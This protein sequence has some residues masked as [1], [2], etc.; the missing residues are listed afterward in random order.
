MYPPPPTRSRGAV[1]GTS[2]T[3]TIVKPKSLRGERRLQDGS[4]YTVFA[5]DGGTEYEPAAIDKAMNTA[6]SISPSPTGKGRPG[7]KPKQPGDKVA[8]S[9]L[10][11]ASAPVTIS[12]PI[13]SPTSLPVDSTTPSPSPPAGSTSSLTLPPT[14]TP[15]SLP[16]G[17]SGKKGMRWFGTSEKTCFNT[18]HAPSRHESHVP[19]RDRDEKG[20]GLVDVCSDSQ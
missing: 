15:T 12:L 14:P 10:A 4:T 11:P 19:R 6:P 5:V 1:R 16:V 13:G 7:K 20:S 8:G 2:A 3:G 9:D 17:T 18:N